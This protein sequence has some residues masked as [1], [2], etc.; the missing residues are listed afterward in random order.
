MIIEKY[1]KGWRGDFYPAFDLW[2]EECANDKH[3]NNRPIEKQ[4][5]WLGSL[6]KFTLKTLKV[7]K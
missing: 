5:E 7:Y 4:N 6:V 1:K 2:K 3:D